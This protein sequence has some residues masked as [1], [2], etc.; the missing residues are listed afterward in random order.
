MMTGAQFDL[1]CR[2]LALKLDAIEVLRNI[3][4]S[5]IVRRTRRNVQELDG[6]HRSR[7]MNRAIHTESREEQ[8][9]AEDLE[10]NT[11]VLEY[12]SQPPKFVVEFLGASGRNLRL[13]QTPDYFVIHQDSAGWIGHIRP[14]RLLALSR[15]QPNRYRFENGPLDLS[16][17]NRIRKTT[18]FDLYRS[19][20]LE[21][22]RSNH[23]ATELKAAF[24]SMKG[25]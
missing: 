1:W 23:V 4:G 19:L 17:G 8:L 21:Y 18:W 10:R 16:A 22:Q 5:S 13:H 7:K 9:L 6:V 12:Y 11:E 3:R 14:E 2:R 20:F 25:G 15:E 24:C